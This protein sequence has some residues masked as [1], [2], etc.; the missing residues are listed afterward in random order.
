M[1]LANNIINFTMILIKLG[2]KAKSHDR[3]AYLLPGN[4]VHRLLFHLIATKLISRRKV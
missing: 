3:V 1:P 2:T 4:Y